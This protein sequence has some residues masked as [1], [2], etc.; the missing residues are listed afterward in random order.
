MSNASENTDLISSDITRKPLDNLRQLGALKF[1]STLGQVVAVLMRSPQHRHTF[2]ADLEWL[3]L[4]AIATNQVAVLDAPAGANAAS[5][6]AAVVLFAMVSAEVDQRLTATP[7]FRVRLKP[8]EWKSG[9]IPWL[10]EAVGEPQ[11]VN[12]LL[13]MVL[14]QR[15]KNTGIKTYSRGTDGKPVVGA[16]RASDDN[17]AAAAAGAA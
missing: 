13:K 4:P 1:T 14:D 12:T 7:G 9:Q 11:A 2:L 6:P 3:V 17:A 8:E 15:F 5:G 16:L 10:V